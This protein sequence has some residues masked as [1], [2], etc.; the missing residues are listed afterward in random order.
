MISNT[1]QWGREPTQWVVHLSNHPTEEWR[2]VYLASEFD[3]VDGANR[4]KALSRSK[5]LVYAWAV[6]AT[7][8]VAAG[9]A[10]FSHGWA[11]LHGLRTLSSARRKGLASAL[12]CALGEQAQKRDLHRFFLQVEEGNAGAINLYRRLGFKVAWRYHYW[13]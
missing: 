7:G 9:T 4:V 10:S 6:D 13:R 3:A 1:L 12:I 2:S 11:S 5:S 8:P